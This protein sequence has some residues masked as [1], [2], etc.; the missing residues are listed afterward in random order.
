VVSSAIGKD[1]LMRFGIAFANTAFYTTAERAVALAQG[2]EAIGVDSLWAVEHVVVPVGYESPYPYS[3]DG[4]MP[5]G[6][7]DFDI[8]DPIVWLTWVAAH[9]TTIKVATGILIVP[10]R[11]PVVVAKEVATLDAM[12]GGR[13]LLGV[14]VGWLREEFDALGESF[15]DRGRRLDEYIAVMRALWSDGPAEFQGEFFNF[16]ALYSRPRPAQGTV[17]IV[18]GGHTEVAARRA[19]RIGDGFFPGSGTIDELRHLI[20]IVRS[21]AE[22]A[23]RDPNVVEITA[24]AIA[25]GNKLYQRVEDLTALG[26][27]RVILTPPR[28]GDFSQAED[29]IARFG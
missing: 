26:V 1:A 28:P 3:A 25:S 21:T 17:P 6:R 24:G 16:G 8:P 27:S 29:L 23:G 9:T 22:A 14:G 4:R 19:G 10:Q 12:S 2:A 20:G 18:I 5:G 11:N 7:E 13:F 15:G